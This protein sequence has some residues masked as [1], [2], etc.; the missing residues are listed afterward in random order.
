MVQYIY[1][2]K[3]ALVQFTKTTLNRILKMEQNTVVSVSTN[4]INNLRWVDFLEIIKTT[5][6]EILDKNYKETNKYSEKELQLFNE[7]WIKLQDEAYV[8]DQNIEA[9]AL[10]K[11]SFERLVLEDK[12]K[13]LKDSCALL[14]WLSDKKELYDSIGREDDF[15]N[16]IQEVYA[17]IHKFNNKIKIEYFK[18]VSENIENISKNVFSLINEYNTK[19]KDIES[20]VDKIVNSI[21]YNVLQVNRITGLNLNANEMKCAE[22]IEAKKI[23]LEVVNQQKSNNVKNE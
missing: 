1:A 14:V 9:K 18:S 2:K 22:W 10:L 3:T 7:A 16:K 17:N 15:N 20:K 4:D 8:L 19:F 23:A 13:Y 11:K 5:K 21:F 12:I 6:Y